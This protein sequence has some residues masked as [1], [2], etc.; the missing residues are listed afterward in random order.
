MKFTVRPM[1][2][3]DADATGYVHWK[4]W[5][6]TY[7]GL[8]DPKVLEN[9]SLTSRQLLANEHPE[10]T[11]VAELNGKIVG[12]SGYGSS[13]DDDLPNSAEIYGIYILQEA[14]GLGIG[15]KLMDAAMA[16]LSDYPAVSI[17]VLQ[18]NEKAIGCY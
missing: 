1:S 7:T 8:M 4:S 9:I 18:G 3:E 11:F 5:K 14:Q 12:F 15:K 16:K 17:W 13:R 10:N 6:E 2:P